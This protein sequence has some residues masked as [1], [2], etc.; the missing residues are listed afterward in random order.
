MAK[1][2][3]TKNT[4]TTL[5]AAGVLDCSAGTIFV[6]DTEKSLRTL[7]SDFDGADIELVIKVKENEEL[8]EPMD[9][10]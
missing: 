1:F 6:D 8:D 4:T 7:F 5:K 10:E 3:Y 2:S 9:E